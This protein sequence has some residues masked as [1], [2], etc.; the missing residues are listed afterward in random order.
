MPGTYNYSIKYN[1]DGS[2]YCFQFANSREGT[3]YFVD[4]FGKDL[5]IALQGSGI[6]LSVA[7]A[8]K[9]IESAYGTHELARLYNNFGGMT[10]ASGKT[11]YA[12][13]MV[14]SKS[15]KYKYAKYASAMDCFKSYVETLRSPSK[16]YV[17]AGL[18]T[19]K[20]PKEQM[21]A[22]AMG[23]YCDM[24]PALQYYNNISK[25]IDLCLDMF[26][27]GKIKIG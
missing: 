1:T 9:S 10:N 11:P 3:R 17:K 23:G 14:L 18:L 7:I 16:K 25:Q 2:V 13:G 4:N 15:G 6:F 19:A 12:T 24:P 26:S 22:I 27:T 5:A 20:T 8:Q 21:Y